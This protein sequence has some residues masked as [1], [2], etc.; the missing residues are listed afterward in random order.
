M[1]LRNTQSSAKELV[2]D[3]LL[4]LSEEQKA[5]CLTDLLKAIKPHVLQTLLQGG[6]STVDLGKVIQSLAEIRQNAQHL[7]TLEYGTD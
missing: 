3:Q 1:T 4:G 6:Q 5:Q 7:T 2:D